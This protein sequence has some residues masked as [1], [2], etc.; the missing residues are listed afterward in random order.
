MANE[1]N[2]KKILQSHENIKKELGVVV[3]SD[4]FQFSLS[5][6]LSEYV[7][8]HSPTTEQLAGVRGFLSVLMNLAAPDEKMPTFPV[9]MIDHSVLQPRRPEPQTK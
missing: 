6:A 5:F 3:N 2:P 4:N 8:N 1:L 9:K 7:I